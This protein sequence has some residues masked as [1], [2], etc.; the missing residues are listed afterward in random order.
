MKKILWMVSC[1]DCRRKY[2]CGTGFD[3]N[4]E[5]LQSQLQALMPSLV[6]ISEGRGIPGTK[7]PWTPAAS[8]RPLKPDFV[9]RYHSILVVLECD[10]DDGH[11]GSRG[12]RIE[13]YG[14]PWEYDR[15]DCLIG[16]DAIDFSSTIQWTR[17]ERFIH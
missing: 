5:A 15:L 8:T 7:S 3:S 10:E 17:Q 11:S 14:E 2:N 12:N 6:F 4:S 13:K 9:F 1:H 16:K